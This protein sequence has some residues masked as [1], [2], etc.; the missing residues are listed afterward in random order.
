MLAT[1]CFVSTPVEEFLDDVYKDYVRFESE[2]ASDYTQE[3]EIKFKDEGVTYY[4]TLDGSVPTKSSK[5][6]WSSNRGEFEMFN[7]SVL[8]VIIDEIG[9]YPV[10]SYTVPGNL[11][12]MITFSSDYYSSTE[13][14]VTIQVKAHGD[15]FYTDDG[16]IP[17][18][19]SESFYCSGVLEK[20]KSIIVKRGATVSVRGMVFHSEC[21]SPVVTYVVPNVDIPTIKASYYTSSAF[22]AQ[23]ECGIADATIYY[24]TDETIPD[25]NDSVYIG[26]FSVP[27]GAT[28]K[29]RAYKDGYWSDVA[30]FRWGVGLL[31]PAGGYVFYDCDADNKT[32]NSDGL[33]SSE[34]GWRFLEV[35]PNDLRSVN[36]IPTIDSSISG[37][38]SA[39]TQYIYGYYRK[40][41]K[42]ENLYLTGKVNNW[43][44]TDCTNTKLG[45]GKSNTEKL[46]DAMGEYAYSSK[47]G[48][49]KTSNYAAHLCEKLEYGGYNDWFLPSWDELKVMCDYFYNNELSTFFAG[50][51][52]SSSEYISN[53]E[54][55]HYLNFSNGGGSK[56]YRDDACYI[57]P[58]RAF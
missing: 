4:Y 50:N 49:S 15:Y 52:W 13:K 53:P 27:Y 20:S 55:A 42:G 3:V 24:T 10:F 14:K 6:S 8:K 29:A 38:S 57:R 7:G 25:L 16:T 48:A 11:D 21:Y 35:A 37:Y 47:S 39:Q 19:N 9:E 23:I 32:G 22:E 34:C 45:T 17:N 41:D 1:S 33:I 30:V 5:R 51:Y 28:I 56:L 26:R 58:I 46:V 44:S 43:T 31:G 36:G 18:K 12:G 2:A 40:D 54:C